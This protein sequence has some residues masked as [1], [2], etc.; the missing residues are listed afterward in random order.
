LYAAGIAVLAGVI[1]NVAWGLQPAGEHLGHLGAHQQLGLPP[2]GFAV[3]TGLP[4]PTCGMTTAFV[5]VMH[6]QL[7]R[8]MQS[9][10]AGFCLAI[11]TVAVGIIATLATLTGYRPAIN[12]YRVSPTKC[13]WATA[14]LLVAAWGIKIAAGLLD[15]TLPQR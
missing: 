6:G 15:G 11:A 14:L 4:C 3:M 1:L 12:G 5:Y 10:L 9:Q 7:W 8:A 13:L 2:C